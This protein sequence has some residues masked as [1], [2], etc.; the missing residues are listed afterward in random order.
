MKKIAVLALAGSMAMASGVAFAGVDGTHHDT[1]ATTGIAVTAG[2]DSKCNYCHSITGLTA[3]N[4]ELGSVGGFCVVACH[5]LDTAVDQ[6]VSNNCEPKSPGVFSWTAPGTFAMDA[7]DSVGFTALTNGHGMDKG[8]VFMGTGATGSNEAASV[9]ATGWPHTAG[10]ALQCTSCH[11]V[12]DATNPPFLNAKLSSGN[13]T[14]GF[15][16]RC[17]TN[18]GRQQAWTG[19]GNHPIEMAWAPTGATGAATRSDDA[20]RGGVRMG[21]REIVVNS[22][23][24]FATDGTGNLMVETTPGTATDLTT[25]LATHWN[26]GGKLINTTNGMPDSTGNFGCYTCH[27]VHVGATASNSLANVLLIG[28]NMTTVCYGCHAMEPGMT[29]YGHPIGTDDPVG[30]GANNG[31]TIPLTAAYGASEF[32]VTAGSAPNCVTCHDVHGAAAGFMAIRAIA[33]IPAGGSACEMCHAQSFTMGTGVDQHHPGGASTTDYTAT[34]YGYASQTA[35]YST[36]D[37]LGDLNEGLSCPDCHVGDQN[38][39]TGKRT[40]AHNWAP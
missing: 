16:Q 38:R 27:T 5:L 29:G 22:V 21:N 9:T 36:A 6:K 40:S 7:T 15:C 32:A 10:N 19:V 33:T 18:T 39:T 2:D 8:V 31:W 11:A 28:N 24:D 17:H 12:H 25:S 4:S 35:W 23:I 13:Q 34:A 14:G 20:L 37:G 30:S 26:L 1:S 3:Q